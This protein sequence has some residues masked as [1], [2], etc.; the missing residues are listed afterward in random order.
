MQNRPPGLTGKKGVSWNHIAKKYHARMT[1]DGK[2]I[3]LGYYSDLAEAKSVRD[4][5]VGLLLDKARHKEAS[6]CA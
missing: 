6:L 1:V 2:T 3:H 5:A 4:K